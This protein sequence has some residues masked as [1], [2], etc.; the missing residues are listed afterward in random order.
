MHPAIVLCLLF[1]V[2]GPLALGI[3]WR[4]DRFTL[5]AKWAL[6]IIVTV[7]SA[8]VT[9]YMYQAVVA[10]NAQLDKVMSGFQM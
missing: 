3:L 1:L 2:L 10:V 6:T 7:Y 8:V 5:T 9:W 4:S